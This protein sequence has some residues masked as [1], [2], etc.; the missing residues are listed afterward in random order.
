MNYHL[1][2]SSFKIILDGGRLFYSGRPTSPP[3]LDLSAC[4]ARIG[5]EMNIMEKTDEGDTSA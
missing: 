3:W 5:E 1:R 2:F 4:N